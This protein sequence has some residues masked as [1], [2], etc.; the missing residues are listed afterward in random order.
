MRCCGPRVAAA[1]GKDRR[2]SGF[3][4]CISWIDF[5]HLGFARWCDEM[6]CR[7]EVAMAGGRE[8]FRPLLHS[9]FKPSSTA[10]PPIKRP[11]ISHQLKMQGSTAGGRSGR[12]LMSASC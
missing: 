8:L 6:L 11:I 1:S 12:L 5:C 4:I 9:F 7:R 3:P 2:C 10:K